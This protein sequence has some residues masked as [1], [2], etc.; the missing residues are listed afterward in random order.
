MKMSRIQDKLS[1]GVDERT[2]IKHTSPAL[3]L[4]AAYVNNGRDSK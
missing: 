4:T 3:L 2:V 1:F